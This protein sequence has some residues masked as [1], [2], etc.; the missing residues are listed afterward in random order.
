MNG[1]SSASVSLMNSI[2][3]FSLSY[4]VG[5]ISY[6]QISEDIKCRIFENKMKHYRY[7]NSLCNKLESNK[8]EQDKMFKIKINQRKQGVDIYIAGE[9]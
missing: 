7:I 1:R 9:I 6:T 5:I 2:I 3:G 4:C 8:L